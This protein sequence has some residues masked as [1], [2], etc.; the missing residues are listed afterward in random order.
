MKKNNKFI[1]PLFGALMTATLLP[2][3]ISEEPFFGDGECTMKMRMVINSDVTR[4]EIDNLDELRENCVL[5]ISD[6]KKGLLYKY[7]GLE[8]VPE[9]ISMKQGSYVAEAWAGDSV[10]ASFDK[11]F[12]RGYQPFMVTAGVNQCVV[13]C[14]I[15]NVVASINTATL[16]PDLVNSYKVTIGN[17]RASLDFDAENGETAKGYY[18][19]PNGETSLTYT[20]EGETSTGSSFKKEGVIES[21]ERAH[22]YILNFECHPEYEEFGGGFITVTVSSEEVLIEDEI[23]IYSRPS[24]SLIENDINHQVVG[25]P[26]EFSELYMKVAAFGG[27]KNI[28]LTSERYEELGFPVGSIDLMQLEHSVATQ[29]QE[30]GLAWDVTTNEARNLHTAIV[31][32]SSEFLNNIPK[33]DEE[34]VINVK[35]VDTY[36]KFNEA[37]IR[38]AVG[39]G[40]IVIEDPVTV[41]P[42]DQNADFMAVGAT[43]ATLKCS[44]NSDE[45]SN[46]GIKYRE[47]GSLDWQFAPASSAQQAQ[48]KK[49]LRKEAQAEMTVI[50]TGLKPGTRYEYK[51]VADGFEASESYFITTE[52]MFVIPDSSFE[53]WGTYKASTMLGTKTVVVPGINHTD[54][55]WD[56]GNEGAATA[57]KQVLFQSSDMVASGESCAKL[58]ST[59]AAGVIAAGNIF[60]GTYVK[61]DGTDGVL[62]LGRPYN[63]SHPTKVVV[64]ANYR[65]GSGVKVKSGNDKYVDVQNG[66]IDQ[67]QVYVALTTAPIEVRTKA[68]NRKLFPAS[69]TNE[70]GDPAEDYDKVVAYGQV[71]WSDAFGPDNGLKTLEIP[72]TYKSNANTT[73]P[74]YLVIVASASKFGDF[75]CGSAESVMYLDDFELVY[76]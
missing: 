9:Q 39:E 7:K 62:S 69:A 11:K 31:I 54:N 49:V 10:S 46:P 5:Y 23:E 55:F 64:Q 12:Y 24:I 37:A 59:S 33:S 52:S 73:R 74:L 34:Y 68:S 8:N 27:V 38:I 20:V 21:V 61:T 41:T 18:M 28:T 66:G 14:K 3:C 26:G 32:F 76:E 2:S 50:L 22:E 58:A 15:A 30:L 16:T 4:A 6:P 63:G 35:A 48:A 53:V 40:A 70:E 60:L 45:V 44:L 72:F 36:G 57:N 67:G 13:N 29:I 65:P 71:T 51:A 42:V 19:M 47:S 43:K 1:L 56:S 25:A 75:Y 17:S